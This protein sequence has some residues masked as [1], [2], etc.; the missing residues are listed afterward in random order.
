[1]AASSSLIFRGK[2]HNLCR[3][4]KC[5]LLGPLHSQECIINF[6]KLRYFVTYGFRN[7][8]QTIPSDGVGF[9][10]N[11][12]WRVVGARW[13]NYQEILVHLHLTFVTTSWAQ[14]QSRS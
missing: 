10:K 11:F 9:S 7:F 6:K 3:W 2:F 8:L 13:R 14:L 5:V 1:M 4:H 12:K